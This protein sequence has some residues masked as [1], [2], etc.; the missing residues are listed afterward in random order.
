M[1]KRHTRPVCTGYVPNPAIYG[2]GTAAA[3]AQG[4]PGD[5]R[6]GKDAINRAGKA[7]GPAQGRPFS[8]FYAA[9]T[10]AQTG[11]L[12]AGHAATG[13]YPLGIPRLGGHGARQLFGGFVPLA[14]GGFELQP[15]FIGRRAKIV[16]PGRG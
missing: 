15:Q 7:K 4:S 10:L 8:V 12:V 6:T 14:D 3:A 2:L 11:G 9:E 16:A 13:V 5:T 1:E